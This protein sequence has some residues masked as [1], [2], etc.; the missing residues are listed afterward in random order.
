MDRDLAQNEGQICDHL[1]SACI[2]SEPTKPP[3]RDQ[4]RNELCKSS[5]ARTRAPRNDT[6]ISTARNRPPAFPPQVCHRHDCRPPPMWRAETKFHRR[7]RQLSRHDPMFALPGAF[8]D[9]P[10]RR[11]TSYSIEQREAPRASIL[12]ANIATLFGAS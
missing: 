4:S 11:R 9:E 6:Q 8:A 12:D 7:L 2:R 1:M 5:C 3:P 10:M